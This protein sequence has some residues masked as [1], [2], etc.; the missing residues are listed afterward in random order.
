MISPRKKVQS[1]PK[2]TVGAAA[3]TSSVAD[4]AL[5]HQQSHDGSKQPE[6]KNY[7]TKLSYGNT[8]HIPF[9]CWLYSLRTPNHQIPRCIHADVSTRL[10]SSRRMIPPYLSCCNNTIA[11]LLAAHNVRGARARD[12]R[13]GWMTG[14]VGCWVGG[15]RGWESGS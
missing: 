15:G 11:L 13:K 7:F 4:E 9:V 2:S 6:K 5:P 3:H 8:V 1:Y 12:V 10:Y 14:L